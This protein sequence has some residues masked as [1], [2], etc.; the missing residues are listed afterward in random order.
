MKIIPPPVPLSAWNGLFPKTD[1]SMPEGFETVKDIARRFNRS[2]AYSLVRLKELE[3][4]GLA[5]SR[6]V[7][8]GRVVMWVFKEI[9]PPNETKPKQNKK[10]RSHR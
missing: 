10:N 2:V 6:L 7:K 9:S 4:Q 1:E 3:K 8:Q 5:E